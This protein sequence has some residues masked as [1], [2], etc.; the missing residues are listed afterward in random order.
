VAGTDDR[1]P[2]EAVT[3]T[4]VERVTFAVDVAVDRPAWVAEGFERVA[5][6]EY[7]VPGVT[8]DGVVR[9][10]QLRDAHA[11]VVANV[12]ARFERTVT[13]SEDGTVVGERRV[14]GAVNQTTE[15]RRLVERYVDRDETYD[16]WANATVGY[17][18]VA[19]GNGVD[20]D[21]LADVTLTRSFEPRLPRHLAF[22][23]TTVTRLDD[24]RYRV[25][26]TDVPAPAYVPERSDR[27]TFV[28]DDRGFVSSA[29]TRA[30][31]IG[32][33]RVLRTFTAATG[34][35]TVER[36]DWLD[37]ARNATVGGN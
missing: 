12:S 11:R 19:H 34:P 22:A 5:E 1:D 6:R 37:A 15:R 25:V 16:T 7:L 23:N 4:V 18:R 31:R 28:V 14:S 35:T 21:R 20:Y 26:A 24:G 13:R 29:E 2:T 17:R 3:V 32:S 10:E 27:V 30:V 8:D 33:G 36:P 9:V